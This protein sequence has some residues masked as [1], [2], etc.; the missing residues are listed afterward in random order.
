MKFATFNA[1][2]PFEVGDKFRDK[3]GKG[4]TITDIVA[5]HHMKTMTVNFV[6]ELDNNGKLVGLAVEPQKGGKTSEAD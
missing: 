3:G 1:R 5:M 4:H 6:Y 2:C